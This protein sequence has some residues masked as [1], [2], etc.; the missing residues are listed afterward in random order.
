ML[1]KKLI[2]N[3]LKVRLTDCRITV[4]IHAVLLSCF[5]AIVLSQGDPGAEGLPGIPG[6]PG[7]DGTPGQKVTSS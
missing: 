5:H 2:V 7:E 4:C 6:Q 3:W 1:Q